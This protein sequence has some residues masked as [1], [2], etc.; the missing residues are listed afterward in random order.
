MD[1]NDAV[2][3]RDSIRRTAH[4]PN[5]VAAHARVLAGSTAQSRYVDI[6]PSQR[7]HV[8]EA[9]EGPPLVLLHGSG[10]TALQFLPLLERL[11]GV[12]ARAVDRPGFGLSDPPDRPPLD[13]EAAVASLTAILDSL[14]LDQTTLLGNSMGGTWALWYALA[15]PDR[16]KRLV[17]LG[18]P[19]LLPGT[20][21]P[22]PLLAVAIP[23]AGPPPPMPAPSR[24]AVVQSMGV[25]GEAETITQ[26]PDQVDAMVAAGSDQ[27]GLG[28]RL[29]ELRAVISP[30]GWQPTLALDVEELRRLTVLTLMIWGDSDPLGGAEVARA[31]AAMFP[32]ARLEVLAAGH[33]PWLGHPDR[34]AR[35]VSDFVRVGVR[36]SHPRAE[37]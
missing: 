25:F 15:H 1:G 36:Y 2:L 11:T 24:E 14:G 18:A 27:I 5:V 7:V 32:D 33:G 22:P 19:P 23:T 31:A 26:Y 35:S 37:T 3:S 28:A 20:Q 9:G 10:P 30:T 8:I 21:V 34:V 13:R 17:L 29:A 12:R 16:V 6:G 4:S